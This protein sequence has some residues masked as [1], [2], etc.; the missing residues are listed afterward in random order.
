MQ[1]NKIIY[2]NNNPHFLQSHLELFLHLTHGPFYMTA[3]VLSVDDN[4]NTVIVQDRERMGDVETPCP[5]ESNRPDLNH[6]SAR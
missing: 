4:G 3:S 1:K 2:N 6:G 5:L